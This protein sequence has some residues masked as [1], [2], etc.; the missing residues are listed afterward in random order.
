MGQVAPPRKLFPNWSIISLKNDAFLL[1]IGQTQSNEPI[2]I[3]LSSRVF[4]GTPNTGCVKNTDAFHIQ[5]NSELIAGICLFPCVHEGAAPFTVLKY[6][7]HCSRTVCKA[8]FSYIVI[9]RRCP[10]G[11]IVGGQR[12]I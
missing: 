2:N 1:L 10:C 11:L 9:H 4:Y 6:L 7:E 5:I 3:T 8:W 12:W